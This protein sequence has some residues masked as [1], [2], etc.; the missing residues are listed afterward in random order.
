MPASLD[1]PGSNCDYFSVIKLTE[2]LLGRF[3]SHSKLALGI[4]FG[5][6]GHR[7]QW[8]ELG[9]I[10]NSVCHYTSATAFPGFF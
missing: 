6:A 3:L 10:R 1:A 4:G 5:N 7:G 8:L 2:Q 9:N